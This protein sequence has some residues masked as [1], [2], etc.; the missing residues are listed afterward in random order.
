[1]FG[2]WFAQRSAIPDLEDRSTMYLA[3]LDCANSNRAWAVRR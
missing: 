2:A 1:M 3:T